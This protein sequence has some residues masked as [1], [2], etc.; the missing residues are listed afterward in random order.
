MADRNAQKKFTNFQ[1]DDQDQIL[2]ELII[3]IIL[4]ALRFPGLD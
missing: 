4:N 2:C 3:S 1:N